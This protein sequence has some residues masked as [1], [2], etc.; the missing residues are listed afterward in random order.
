M[1]NR[2]A[3]EELPYPYILVRTIRVPQALAPR[4]NNRVGRESKSKRNYDMA[5]GLNRWTLV[6]P[7][8]R[9]VLQRLPWLGGATLVG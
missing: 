1:R 8:I 7:R 6:R 5:V 3:R 2:G 9:G 4:T